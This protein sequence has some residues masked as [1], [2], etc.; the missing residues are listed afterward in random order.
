MSFLQPLL[1]AALPLIA[2]PVVIHLINQRRYQ[3]VRWAAMMFLLAANRMS[4]GYARVRQWLILLAR[5]LA[6]AGLIFA[7]S[8]PLA[9]GLVGRAAGDRPD[10]TIVLLDRSPSMRQQGAGSGV[11]KLQTGREQLART[12]AAVGSGRW[13]LI[14]GATNRPAEIESPDSLLRLTITEPVSTSADLPAMLEAA[15]GYIRDNK[16]GRTDVWVCS[17]LREND[18]HPGRRPVAGRPRLVRRPAAGGAGASARLPRP[19]GRQR[20]GAG[21]ERAA[22]GHGRRGRTAGVAETH[23]GRRRGG[24]ARGAGAVR[25]R[26]HPVRVDGGSH[27]PD[28]RA[29]RPPHPHRTD[30]GA[31]LGQGVGAGRRQPGG[32][33]VLLHLR[34]YP[35]AADGDRVGGRDP[36]GGDPVGRRHLARADGAGRR[37]GGA[38]GPGRRRRVGRS[39]AG[40]VARPAAGRAGRRGG[41][42]VR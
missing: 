34:P 12:L 20:R 2:L 11:S 14:D 17:D 18:W 10:T 19:A 13:V 7:V 26:G 30:P 15:R 33:R 40:G 8:R 5:T 24:E 22:G 42:G 29:D 27:R 28:G 21:D 32:Q 25:H 36:I 37:R 16:A 23:P 3:T 31:R 41:A 4:R 38:A 35:A 9:G 39:R 6:V 1:L